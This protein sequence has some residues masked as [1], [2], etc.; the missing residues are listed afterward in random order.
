MAAIA[1]QQE[2][3]E[4]YK[5]VT[6][7]PNYWQSL[8][9]NYV[10]LINQGQYI[11]DKHP[12]QLT[13]YNR[14]LEKGADI[15]SRAR[16]INDSVNS[17]KSAW[18]EFTGWLKGTVGLSGLGVIPVAVSAVSAGA[19]IY[20]IGAWLREAA[21][22]ARRIEA[23]KQLEAQGKTPQEAADIVSK[24]P[25]MG[26]GDI[27]KQITKFFPWIVIGGVALFILPRFLKR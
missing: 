24:I 17:I 18:S 15:Y 21:D 26:T 6:D 3:Q 1:N 22:F 5:I 16:V 25:G 2:A 20:S 8:E 7:W 23:Q 27:F 4:W 19:L 13:E 9:R 12:E 10:G 14:M 11:R